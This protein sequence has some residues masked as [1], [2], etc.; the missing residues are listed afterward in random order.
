MRGFLL[1]ITAATAE[2][3]PKRKRARQKA[4]LRVF[5]NFVQSITRER[6]PAARCSGY[7]TTPG[8]MSKKPVAKVRFHLLRSVLLFP[9][10]ISLQPF[11]L[12]DNH[13]RI[14]LPLCSA[15][16]MDI[17]CS[18][19]EYTASRRALLHKCFHAYLI[20]PSGPEAPVSGLL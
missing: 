15:L 2:V 16:L 13:G 3:F 20:S 4:L 14:S 5:A 18:F 7:I 1:Y 17:R 8:R 10:G 11:R 12:S 6:R 19:L 9:H